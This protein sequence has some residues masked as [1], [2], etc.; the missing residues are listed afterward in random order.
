LRT[1]CIN[2][3]A[4]TIQE[5]GLVNLSSCGFLPWSQSLKFS[6][7]RE[8]IDH[9]WREF[10][11]LKNVEYNHDAFHV[12]CSTHEGVN[13]TV[14]KYDKPYPNPVSAFE[15]KRAIYDVKQFFRK[16][17][18]KCPIIPFDDVMVNPDAVTGLVA[19]K[20]FDI[21]KKDEALMKMMPYFEK[22]WEVAHLENYPWLW[23][24][25]GKVE[26]LKLQKLIDVDIRGFTIIPFDAFLA[27]ARMY[28]AMNEAMCTPEFYRT[29]P[30]KHGLNM[31]HGG[32]R[33]L[34]IEL[35]SRIQELEVIEGDCV[36]WDSGMIDDL[37]AC[38][39]EIRF[40]CW[41]KKGMS[42]KE[43]WQRTNYYYQEIMESYIGLTTG[44]VLQKM[45]GNPSG[46]T[47][48]TDDNCIG[49][50]Y[51]LC[52]FWRQ[53]YGC[54]L[55]E[56]YRNKINLAIYADDHLIVAEKSLKFGEFEP[57]QMGYKKHGCDLS[58]EKDL[59]TDTFEGHTFLGLTATWN[60]Q[61]KTY[62]PKFSALKTLNTLEKYECSYTIEQVFDR[63]VT[64]L[65]LVSFDFDTF[66]V[67]ED[68]LD[69]LQDKYPLQLA[70]RKIPTLG[71][72]HSFWLCQEGSDI[73]VPNPVSITDVTSC[74]SLEYFRQSLS[75]DGG[76]EVTKRNYLGNPI[77]QQGYMPSPR[78][79]L[80][81]K[82]K[83]GKITKQEYDQR[84]AQI[85]AAKKKARPLKMRDFVAPVVRTRVRVPRG[86]FPLSNKVPR[87]IFKNG[88]GERLWNNT[89]N[90][91]S[92]GNPTYDY[93][94]TMADPAQNIARVPDGFARPT[95]VLRS[96]NSFSVPISQDQY[97]TGRFSFA[98]SPKLGDLSDPTHYQAA[99]AS[100]AHASAVT[101]TWDK[102]DWGAASSYLGSSGGNDP[103]L[104][105]NEGFLTTQAPSYQGTSFTVGASNDLSRT[106]L[107]SGAGG[108][109]DSVNTAPLIQYYSPNAPGFTTTTAGII[110]LPFGDW[111]ISITAKFQISNTS[112]TF[113]AINFVSTS[114]EA[115]RIN[116]NQQST[117]TTAINTT[118]I[119]SATAQVASSPG[120]NFVGFCL[121]NAQSGLADATPDPIVS[122]VSATYVTITAA[123]FSSS[124]V[125]TDAGVLQEVRP[126]AMAVLVTY[127]GTLLNNGGEI[128]MAY[129]PYDSLQN[130]YLAQNNGGEIGQLQLFENLR[131]VDR[132][133]D[134][135][136][137][138]GAYGIWAPESVGD[139]AFKSPGNMNASDYPAIIC[140]GVF[141]PDSTVNTTQQTMRVMV[142]IVYE[143]VTKYTIFETLALIGSQ[144]CCDAAWTVIKSQQ[145]M[146]GPNGKHLEWIK[147]TLGSAA[148]FYKNNAS[149]INPLLIAAGS[150]L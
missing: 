56:D 99:V 145:S 53:R 83:N 110:V 6:K 68:Y 26:L 13:K 12:S 97:N 114:R 70:H 39:K 105:S 98:V 14:L 46:Q 25:A 127:M 2:P 84:I 22:F 45:F 17:K 85:S 79:K 36:K 74:F 89:G 29:S 142:Y 63:A 41:D 59:V 19:Q 146:C 72:C 28:Q 42:E 111:N 91:V 48:T 16:L 122:Q 73:E 135:K 11:A 132:A 87:P 52:D 120:K 95:G 131:K 71:G 35:S 124:A 136:I 64:L 107:V 104:D 112:S 60:E 65:L 109:Q 129:V 148:S 86:A 93:V 137:K 57:R 116:I 5:N 43:W 141:S 20:W 144:A 38:I 121:D 133:Y 94:K 49:H 32:F 138:D 30:L 139:I 37:F 18:D 140:S 108:V 4:P 75:R 147:R 40:F 8:K 126:V 128:A 119:A 7:W 1:S 101:S 3:K 55:F 47:S 88:T 69:Y 23:K 92:K 150:L 9:D 62:V 58:R 78:S 66:K 115:T 24:Q 90:T 33:S 96:I 61:L 67:V 149:L 113:E 106:V 117:P 123:N 118:Y 80:N 143:F 76:L 77:I 134:G 130:N 51:V 81:K 27:T 34:L 103:R 31:T 54:S 102:I 82:L 15:K 125:Y 21:C 100:A 10:C 44:Q 50:L